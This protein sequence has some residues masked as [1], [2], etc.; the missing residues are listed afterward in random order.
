MKVIWS[1]E[2]VAHLQN[3]FCGTDGGTGNRLTQFQLERAIKME[4]VK[5]DFVSMENFAIANKRLLHSRS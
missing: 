4:I 1:I 2:D 3:F 5:A